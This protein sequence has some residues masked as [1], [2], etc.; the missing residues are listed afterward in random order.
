MFKFPAPDMD[1]FFRTYAITT[2]AVSKDEKRIAFS[3]NLSGKY[4]VWGLDLPNTYPYPLTYRDQTPRALSFDPLGRFILVGFDNDGDENV[5]LYAI[6][7]NGGDVTP[8]RTFEGRRHFFARLSQDG[9]RLYYSSD[10]E[11]HQFLNGYVYDLESGEEKVLYEGEGGANYIIRVSKDESMFIV[12]THFANT[13]MPA[14]VHVDGKRL[15]L[16]PDETVQHVAGTFDFDGHTIWF[17]TD[18]ESDRAYLA[19]FNVDTETF[20][21]VYA[22]EDGDIGGVNIHAPSGKLYFTVERGAEDALVEYNLATG[23]A[24]ELATPFSVIEE[25][26]VG[27]SGSIYVLGRSDV[28]PFNLYLRDADGNWTMLTQNRVMGTTREELSQAEVVTFPSYDGLPIEALWFPANKERANGYTVVWP[29]GGPQAAERRAFRPFFQYLCSHGYNVWAPNFRGSSGYGTKFVK[30]V[31]GDWGEGP[32]LD[33]VESM[34]FLIREG[35]AD[36]DKL[37]LVGGSYGGYMTL[38][39]HGRHADY[40]QACVDIF[41]PSNL[42]TFLNSVPDHWK[43]AM[44]Q[45]LGDVVEDKERLTKDSP[46]TY[47]EGMTKPMLVIQGA[48]DPRVVKAESD[49]IVAALRDKGREIEYIVFD[50]EGHGF[51]KKENEMKAYGSTVAFLDKY[52]K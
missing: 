4:N 50:D 23:E 37:F 46:I 9:Q 51:M 6:S 35:K 33:M 8:I 40:F 18:Y 36:R 34:E 42:F 10:K 24:K 39:L 47:L 43:P 45:W 20:E 2:F 12:A 7:Q 31:E 28:D 49:Q 25:L 16:V 1:E 19:K 17:S 14:H 21:K 27:E 22:L 41:G 5:Q 30:M 11:N 44:K 13:F 29:H 3:T 26:Q 52:R 32:R 48:N 38:L 15:S